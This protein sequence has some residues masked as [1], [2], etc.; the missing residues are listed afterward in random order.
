MLV[1]HNK[2]LLLQMIN[3]FLPQQSQA[4]KLF[5]YNNFPLYVASVAFW[6][7]L[8]QRKQQLKVRKKR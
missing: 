7:L 1:F 8:N 6:G 2:K 5:K 3:L 4:A